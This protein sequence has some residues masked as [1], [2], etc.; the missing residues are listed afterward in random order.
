MRIGQGFDAHRFSE[1]SE[2]ILGGVTIPHS[3]GIAA[4][5]DGDVLLHAICD[6]L[7]GAVG[8]GDIGSH[9]PNDD[10]ANKNRNSREF[11]IE[12]MQ[13][14]SS[15]EKRVINIDA[16]IIL[17]NPKVS[18]YIQAMRNNIAQDLQIDVDSVNIKATTT[19]KMGFTGRGE[20]V[21]ALAVALVQ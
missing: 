16:T 18:S 11:L 2:I 3:R 8:L 1:G 6:A 5:S 14:I 17:Q 21:A 4:H 20:G 15:L 10:I 7:L 9:F 13:K 12:V 19:E